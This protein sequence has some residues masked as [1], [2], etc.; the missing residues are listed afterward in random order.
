MWR[1]RAWAGWKGRAAVLLLAAVPCAGAPGSGAVSVPPQFFGMH[2]HRLLQG[3]PWPAAGIGAW[4]MWDARVDWRSIESRRGKFDFGRLDRL[5]DL[6]RRQG[7]RVLLPLGLSP[8][9][10]SLRPAEASAYDAGNA[11]P[12]ARI[13][14][15]TAYVEAV[16]SRYRGR[17]EAYEIWNEPN[18]SRFF[19]GSV[20]DAV[21]LACE[22]ARVIKAQDPAALVVS[23]A[24]T[25]QADGV[26]WL[27]GFLA[28]GGGR[29]VDVIGFHFYTQA[30]E[31]PEALLPLIRAVR[32]AM[33]DNGA[34]DKPLWNTESGW[35]AANSRVPVRKSFTVIGMDTARDYVM[36]AHILAAAE[37]IDRFYWYAWDN[38]QMGMVEPDDMQW[39]PVAKGYRTVASW[40]G[41]GVLGPCGRSGSV[42][43]C[44]LRSPAGSGVLLWQEGRGAAP[45]PYPG[46]IPG[47]SATVLGWDG[48]RRSLGEGERPLVSGTP[49]FVTY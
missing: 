31:T 14:D 2:F 35:F 46:D 21:G 1:S 15:W 49:I 7:V 9:W 33:Q 10:A 22:A 17:I 32:G 43:R 39:K 36:R 8:A 25:D 47:N 28:A 42:W 5:V 4:R 23:P 38:Q 16:V 41:G 6:A 40:L 19:S 48:S 45:V 27:K 34:G 29:C 3:T 11:A 13:A 24:A 12:P 18:R 37:G 44:E 20:E 30:H 26:R